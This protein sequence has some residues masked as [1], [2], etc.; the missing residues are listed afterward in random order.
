MS[1]DKP[2]SLSPADQSRLAL[3]IAEDISMATEVDHEQAFILHG[4]TVILFPEMIKK[5][6]H[7]N[8][9]EGN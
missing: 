8:R 9:K 1:Q 2:K 6:S 7:L 5:L 3:R 4:A